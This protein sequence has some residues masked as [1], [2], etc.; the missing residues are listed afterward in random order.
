MSKNLKK[1]QIYADI[2]PGKRP[3]FKR[4]NPGKPKGTKSKF[5][6]LKESYLETFIKLDGSQGLYEWAKKNDRNKALFYQ[7][8]T[9]MLPSNLDV[10][11][12][13]SISYEVSNKF[14]P[15]KDK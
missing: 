8:I 2:K 6:N 13:I 9:K 12:Q 11:G 10:S 15:K 4:G 1:A 3:Q 14:L 7:M 5:T